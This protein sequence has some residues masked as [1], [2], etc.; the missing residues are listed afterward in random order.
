VTLTVKVEKHLIKKS[1]PFFEM[2][3]QFCFM[4]KN[5]YNAANYIVRQTFINDG[6]WVRYQDLDKAL[7]QETEYTDYRDMPSAQ[8][9]QQTLR[10]LDKNWTSFFKAI[11]AYK[12]NPESFT[13]KP[14]LPKYKEKTGRNILILTNQNCKLVDGT[15]YFPKTFKGFTIETKV[16][17]LNQIRFLP[18]G[19]YISIEVVYEVEDVPLAEDNERYYSIDIGLDN[20][21]TVV[22]NFGEQPFVIDGKGLKSMNQYYNKK[23]AVLSSIA[24][25]LNKRYSTKRITDFTSKRNRKVEDYMHKASRLLV[26]RA[27]KDNVSKI[28]VGLNKDFKR[29]INIGK[30][31]NQKFVMIPFNSLIQK[32]QYKAASVG[33]EVILTEESYTSG[34]SF[35][36]GEL[37]VKENY[38]KK[39]RKHRGLFV[40]NQGIRINADVNG[41]YQIFKKVFPNAYSNGIEGVGLHPIVFTI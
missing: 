2:L 9:A 5:L 25:K 32:I 28:I 39:R 33:I 8:A 10:L 11:K 38:D 41:A 17:N 29:E 4:S 27:L 14:N 23:R 21:L 16:G 26:D 24:S 18:M 22:N 19:N 3:D 40:S 1:N 35:L 36:D 15:I 31:N 30:V 13:G 12:R 20:L 34:T 7:K 6:K 37:P